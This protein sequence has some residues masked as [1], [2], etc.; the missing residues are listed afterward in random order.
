MTLAEA[1]NLMDQLLEKSGAPW[2]NAIEKDRF[3][4][5]AQVEFAETRGDQLEFNERRREDLVKIIRTTTVTASDTINLTSITNFM[6]VASVIGTFN[7]VNCVGNVLNVPV[8]AARLNDGHIENN[9][10]TDGINSDPYYKQYNDGTNS[11]LKVKSETTPLSLLMYYLKVPVNVNSQGTPVVE[12]EL[13]SY[14]HDQLVNIAVRKAMM[15]MQD[16]NYPVQQN[17]IAKQE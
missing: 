10:F 8:R 16:Q 11:I 9:P 7:D 17:E 12:F 1:H 3:L 5:M 4:N 13:P 14:V 2:Q 6:R 15:P